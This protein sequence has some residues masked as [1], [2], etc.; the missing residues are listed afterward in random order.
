MK[1]FLLITTALLIIIIGTVTFRI[2]QSA[3]VFY[4]IEPHFSG[5]CEA[6]PGVTGAED[7][8][9]DQA[10]QYAYISAINRRRTDSN[11]P[12]VAG[13]YGLDLS[14]PK[15]TPVLLSKGFTSDFNPH[16][17]SLY[18]GKEHKSLFVINHLKSGKQ[19]VEIFD[20]KDVDQ[21]VHRTS[22]SYPGLLT[23]N[24]LVAVGPSQ[25]YVSNDHG[26]QRGSLMRTAEDYLGFPLANVSYFDG[27]N[28]HIVADGLRYANGI[29]VSSDSKTLY[30]VEV[31][32][33]KINVYDR[34]IN[35]GALTK[36]DEIALNSGA[37]NLE[38][39]DAGNL[40]LAGHPRLLE[41][42]A[43]ANDASKLSPSQ[44]IKINLQSAQQD[45]S[46]AE[47]TEVLLST[48]SDISGSS[49]AAVSGDIMLVGSVFEAHILRCRL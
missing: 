4:A 49:V 6:V 20:I 8:T 42:V 24:D 5:Q 41:F 16:G 22:V 10:N 13:I 31:T 11:P 26:S 21:L 48:G 37:D 36:R 33:R 29:T 28:G 2:A 15:A 25:F 27:K 18:Q 7:I 44:V 39:D 34:D 17:F 23:P 12:F 46:Q 30:V 32:G 38:W 9:I 45:I 35:S 43:H 40:W 14:N 19:Q 1:R 47:V 3:G